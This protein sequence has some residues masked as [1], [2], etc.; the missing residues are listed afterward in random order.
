M[1]CDLHVY[2]TWLTCLSHVIDMFIT[3]L[4]HVC[5]AWLTCSSHVLTCS[6]HVIDML[7]ARDWDVHHMYWDVHHVIDMFVTW[8]TCVSHVIDMR[9]WHVYRILIAHN[10]F[11]TSRIYMFTRVT[12]VYAYF[13]NIHHVI[14]MFSPCSLHT[15]NSLAMIG[16]GR[17]ITSTTI[18][19]RIMLIL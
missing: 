8:L 15:C 16:D 7:V 4:W 5:R 11:V 2:H 19:K 10:L 3:W 1:I 6:S 9:Y 18:W 12:H 14:F 13:R 17:L